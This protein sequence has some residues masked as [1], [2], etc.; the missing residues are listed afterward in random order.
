VDAFDFTMFLLIMLL[1]DHKVQT[2]RSRPGGRMMLSADAFEKIK[3]ISTIAGAKRP[4]DIES[5]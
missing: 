2:G 4:D 3:E 1:I 5:A